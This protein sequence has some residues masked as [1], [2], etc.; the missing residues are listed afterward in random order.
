MKAGLYQ[1]HVRLSG[2]SDDNSS[3]TGLQV[4]GCDVAQCFFNA[5]H[6]ELYNTA[7]I[8]ELKHLKVDDVLQV[9][10]GFNNVSEDKQALQN[11]FSLLYLG[12]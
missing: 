12:K 11:C 8:T 6:E 1:I 2:I 5:K 10:C 9:N 3:H 7:H 4:N